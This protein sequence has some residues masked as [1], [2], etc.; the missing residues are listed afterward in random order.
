MRAQVEGREPEGGGA[1]NLTHQLSSAIFFLGD[2]LGWKS[3]SDS[4]FASSVEP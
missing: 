4:R 1:A 2:A 3:W